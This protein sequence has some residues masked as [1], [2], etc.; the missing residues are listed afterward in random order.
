MIGLAFLVAVLRGTLVEADGRREEVGFD[1]FLVELEAGGHR[2]EVGFNPF[3]LVF[4]L[5]M[6]VGWWVL[7]L[8][9][10]AFLV[11]WW[12]LMI[13]LPIGWVMIWLGGD[14]GGL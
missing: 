14:D 10:L 3:F 5:I 6:G 4:W 13:L 7:I 2:K 1:P 9:D 8:I 11:H 12:V